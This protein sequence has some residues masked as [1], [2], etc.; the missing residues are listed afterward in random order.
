MAEDTLAERDP[1]FNQSSSSRSRVAFILSERI[2]KLEFIAL[3]M[4]KAD[5]LV[6]VALRDAFAD[7]LPAERHHFLAA[8]QELIGASRDQ[9]DDVLSSLR[10][11][12]SDE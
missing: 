4:A 1:T 9:L 10:Q 11:S 2:A 7:A 6:S 8:L 12:K 3:L 5:A